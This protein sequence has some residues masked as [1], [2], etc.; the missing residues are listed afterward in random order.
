[1]LKLA[2]KPILDKPTTP[3]LIQKLD[4]LAWHHTQADRLRKEIEAEWILLNKQ[5]SERFQVIQSAM[6]LRKQQDETK[7]RDA[8]HAVNKSTNGRKQPAWKQLVFEE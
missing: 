5:D 8:K 4:Q 2:P 1:M 7:R 3:E 6:R